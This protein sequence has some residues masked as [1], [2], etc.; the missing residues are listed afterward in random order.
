ML[1]LRS[2]RSKL[3]C[4]KVHL[5]AE[6]DGRSDEDYGIH[7]SILERTFNGIEQS[8]WSCKNHR[9]QRIFIPDFIRFKLIFLLSLEEIITTASELDLIE[10]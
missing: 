1:L 5:V 8:I 2:I 9:V 10:D 6:K 3:P 4:Q 7:A